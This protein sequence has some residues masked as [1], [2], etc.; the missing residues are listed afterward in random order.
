MTRE[1]CGTSSGNFPTTAGS[2]DT[3]YNGLGDV[4]VTKINPSATGPAQLA[5]ST[6]VGGTAG[7]GGSKI[8]LDTTGNVYVVGSTSST[9]FPTVAPLQSYGGA[10][11]AFVTK[12]NPSTNALI[13][14]TSSV[15]AQ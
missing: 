11:D 2:Y 15:A 7:D 1:T 5:Y 14:S 6:F 10:Q 9:N 12:L 3:T 13:Y 4:F 8:A